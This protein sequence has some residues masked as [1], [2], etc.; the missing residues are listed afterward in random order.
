MRENCFKLH[1]K[2]QVLNR[3]GGFRG[4]QQSQAYFT[5]GEGPTQEKSNPNSD[6]IGELKK[7]EI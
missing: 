2:T 5:N 3:N 6:E 1:G 4:Q 7:E